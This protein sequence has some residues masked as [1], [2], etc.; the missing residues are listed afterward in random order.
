VCPAA[1]APVTRAV[2]VDSVKVPK[3][4]GVEAMTGVGDRLYLAWVGHSLSPAVDWKLCLA[5][6]PDGGEITGQQRLEQRSYGMVT[7]D[8]RPGPDPGPALAVSGEHLYLAW[9]DD[10]DNINILADPLSPH[11]PPARLDEARSLGGPVLCSHQG[12]L[13]FTRY[14]ENGGR[15]LSRLD[16]A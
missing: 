6:S 9:T 15:Y 3:G 12:S 10:D 8:G 11:D 4:I 13:F 14:G 5:Y 1:R 16:W 2:A 7:R